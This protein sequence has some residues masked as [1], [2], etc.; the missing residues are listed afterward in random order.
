MQ[1]FKLTKDTGLKITEFNSN[2]YL[3]KIIQSNQP[4]K[5]SCMHLGENGIIG[6]H[7][8]TTPQLFLIINGKGL[9][10]GKNGNIVEVNSGSA[11]FWDKNE[12]HETRTEDGLIAI[13]IESEDID[14][15]ILNPL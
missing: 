5:I 4:V 10:K 12:W 14:C 7:Q 15:S 6:L 13:A 2:F 1:F 3:S 8:A 11:V 9:V